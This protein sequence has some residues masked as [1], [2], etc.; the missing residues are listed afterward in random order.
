MPGPGVGVGDSCGLGVGTG[1]GVDGGGLVG[2]RMEISVGVGG[3]V[4]FEMTSTDVGVGAVIG[5]GAPA[6]SSQNHQTAVTAAM[7]IG[8][9]RIR[10]IRV[11]RFK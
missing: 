8:T 7:A 4:A 5:V 9:R 1:V 11:L 2:R 10:P 6:I 3:D